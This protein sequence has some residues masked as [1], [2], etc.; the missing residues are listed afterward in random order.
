MAVIDPI[1]FS[2]EWT[3]PANGNVYQEKLNASE[4]GEWLSY[5]PGFL[6]VINSGAYDSHIYQ[7]A[8]QCHLRHLA[9]SGEATDL[10]PSQ[11]SFGSSDSDMLFTN[12]HVPDEK[13]LYGG[14]L[15]PLP[16]SARTTRSFAYKGLRYSRNRAIGRFIEGSSGF[17]P[18]LHGVWLRIEDIETDAFRCRVVTPPK[19]NAIKVGQVILVEFKTV[20]HLFI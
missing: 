16:A 10:R 9:T 8:A 7:I 18:E 1:V 6:A 19:G 13:K 5:L 14:G 12:G 3:D 20:S 15:A 2:G 17:I 4:L 11:P